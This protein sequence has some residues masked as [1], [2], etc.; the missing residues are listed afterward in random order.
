MQKKLTLVGA[1]PGD[2]E[3]ISLKG[4]RALQQADVVL[5]DA[6]VHP[7]LLEYVSPRAHQVFVGKRA[8]HHYLAQ[9]EINRLIVQYATQYGHVVRLKGGDPFVF[10]RGHEELTYAREH[11]L[12]VSVVPGISSA[13][14]LAALQ[15]VPLTCRGVNESF[16]VLTGT[17]KA[18]TLSE[19]VALAARSSATVIVLMGVNKLTEIAAQ[20]STRGKGDLPVMIIQNGSLPDERVI[21]G[22]VD[23]IVSIAQTE[24]IGSPA[25]LVFGQV[26]AL[27]PKFTL[28]Y[29]LSYAQPA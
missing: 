4:V 22:T 9:E 25:I 15:E 26:V 29:A 8:G 27:H 28:E 18:G 6:L 1:G 14:S 21:L 24:G 5:Y 13:T 10:G 20:F 11:G 12:E 19:D 2:P 17:T 16:W 3:L 23:T 7:D